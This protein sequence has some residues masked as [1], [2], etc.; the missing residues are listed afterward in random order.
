MAEKIQ[1][2][3]N[4]T[5]VY[6]ITEVNI[7]GA[8]TNQTVRTLDTISGDTAYVRK[9]GVAMSETGVDTCD[10]PPANLTMN[11]YAADGTLLGSRANGGAYSDGAVVSAQGVYIEFVAAGGAGT[12]AGTESITFTDFGAMTVNFPAETVGNGDTLRLYLSSTSSTYYDSAMKYG[13]AR[14][15]PALNDEDLPYRD[16]VT[17]YA[18]L[19]SANDGV[20][21]LDSETYDYEI[22]EDRATTFMQSALGQKARITGG[23]GSRESREVEHDGNNTDTIYV[24]DATGSDSTGDGTYQLPYASI[25]YAEDN[26]GGLSWIHIIDSNVY[27]ESM[28]V[29]SA[30]SIESAYGFTPIIRKSTAGASLVSFTHVDASIYGIDIDSNGLAGDGINIS[31]NS[32]AGYIKDNIVRNCSSSGV[33]VTGTNLFAGTI[34]RNKI[35]SNSTGIVL[36]SSTNAAGEIKRNYIYS[37]TTNGVSQTFTGSTITTVYRNNVV[38]NNGNDGISLGGSTHNGT[39]ENNTTV[40][41]TGDGLQAQLSV[42]FGGIYRN[43]MSWG[44]GGFDLNSISLVHPSITESNYSTKNNFIIGAG[45]ITTDPVFADADNDKFGIC[46]NSG[47]LKTDTSSDDMGAHLRVVEIGA[48]S[49]VL[50]GLI[51][52]GQGQYFNG[53]F[54]TATRT[55]LIIKW[56]TVENFNG[57]AIDVYGTGNTTS[58]VQDCIVNDNGDGISF[59]YGGNICSQNVVYNNEQAGLYCDWTGQTF[60]HNTYY[61]NKYGI[62]IESNG[63]GFIIKNS[64]FDSSGTYDIFSEVSVIVTYSCVTGESNSNVTTLP[65]GDTNNISDS[66]AFLDI[67]IGSEDLR[68]QSPSRGSLFSSPC[69]NLADDAPDGSSINYDM[70]A[71]LETRGVSDDSWKK[72]VFDWNPRSL[73]EE[74]EMMNYRQTR[75]SFGNLYPAADNNKVRLPFKWDARQITSKN[76]YDK[77]RFFKTRVQTRK[78]N[79]IREGTFFRAWL[80]PITNI[81]S[82]TCTIDVSALSITDGSGDYNEDRWNEYWMGVKFEALN[83]V[84]IS[85]TN[86]TFTKSGAGWSTDQW[87]NW[88][89][90][91]DGYTYRVLT[92]DGTILYVSDP[93][94]TLQDGTVNSNIEY[95]FKVSTHTDKVFTVSDPDSKLLT[96]NIGYYIGF[97]RCVCSSPKHQG[98]QPRYKFDEVTWKTGFKFEV[99]SV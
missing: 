93:N 47:A 51:I 57:K 56:C 41:N 38:Y 77:V 54:E 59:A 1:I 37:S 85:A 29:D 46:L 27:N 52:D 32:Y 67:T 45:N 87:Q 99:E 76:D 68:L 63:G 16:P 70:G 78:N 25:Q 3:Y 62:Y 61:N 34:D 48:N 80:L 95:Y 49:I 5:I 66:P 91:Y 42:A 74:T 36:L 50:N 28:V 22:D 19:D 11:I 12:L 26:M 31:V 21:F 24:S 64:I 96:T 4:H 69:L 89:V 86:K 44:N 7:P 84:V 83:S 30:T 15:T 23:V 40:Y 55:G 92:N 98:K 58:I 18:A 9:F 65:A 43:N 53:I 17:A 6:L 94:S 8:T 20:V 35:H 2:D 72:Y 60:D 75:D 10:A 82:G 81:I 79:L 88:F 73:D 90:K 33:E 39:I 13:G 14:N 97:L 71:Y